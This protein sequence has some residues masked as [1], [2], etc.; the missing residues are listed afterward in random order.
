MQKT[1]DTAHQATT[2]AIMSKQPQRL[3]CTLRVQDFHT[4]FRR[5]I[6]SVNVNEDDCNVVPKSMKTIAT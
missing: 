3:Y 4:P 1:D 6:R 5:V 2:K